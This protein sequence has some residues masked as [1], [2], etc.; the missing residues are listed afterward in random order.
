[1]TQTKIDN[2][3]DTM[4]AKMTDIQNELKQKLEEQYRHTTNQ[5]YTMNDTIDKYRTYINEE[6]DSKAKFINT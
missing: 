3:R 2:T 1:M 4:V 6:M 5:F